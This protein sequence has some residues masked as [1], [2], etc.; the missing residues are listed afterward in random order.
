M[1]SEFCSCYINGKCRCGEER[2]DKINELC[3]IHCDEEEPG[4]NRNRECGD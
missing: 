3:C 4:C 1:Q 2:C